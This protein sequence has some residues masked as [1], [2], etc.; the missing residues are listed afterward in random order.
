MRSASHTTQY[1]G[2]RRVRF[3]RRLV[4][5]LEDTTRGRD[6]VLKLR[7]DTGDFIE[8]LR[9]LVRVAQERNELPDRDEGPD[10]HHRAAHTDRR[11]DDRVHAAG[12]RIHE[13]RHEGRLEA[14]VG[15]GFIYLLKLR[16]C[17]I[18]MPEGLHDLQISD[19]LFREGRD[20]AAALRLMTEESIGVL[21]DLPRHHE[22]ERGQ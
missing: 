19:H 18:L 7:H 9:V 12:R 14:V 20:L 2:V 11:I 15:Q 4:D 22:A 21:R 1:H 8:R 3:H 5:D 17:L 16:L 10:R 13:R 6:G